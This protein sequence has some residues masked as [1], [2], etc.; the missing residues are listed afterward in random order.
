[1][2][3]E[4][5]QWSLIIVMYTTVVGMLLYVAKPLCIDSS[6]VEKI[7]RVGLSKTETIYKCSAMVTV[8]YSNYFDEKKAEIE[9]RIESVT[10]FLNRMQPIKSRIYLIIDETSPLLFKVSS[11]TSLNKIQIGSQLLEAR[12]HLERA[13]IKAWL[14]EKSKTKAQQNLFLEVA[15]DFLYYAF[16]GSFEIEDPLLKVQTKLGNSRWPQVLKSKDGYCESPWKLSE[17]YWICSRFQTENDLTEAVLNNLSIRPLM[18]SVWIKAFS[19]LTFRDQLTFM[20]GFVDYLDTQEL[21]SE[22]AIQMILT[23]SHP[24]K[25]G[26]MNIKKMTDRMNSSKFMQNRKDYREFF[27]R[28]TLNLQQAGV[29][30]SFAEAY[31]DYLFEYPDSLTTDSKLFQSLAKISEQNPNLQFAV[32]DQ[33]QIWILPSRSA[34]PLKTFDKIKNQQHVFFACPSLKEIKMEQFY[35]QSEKL[36]LIK[37]CDEQKDINFATLVTD[38]VQSFSIKN[39]KLAFIQFHLPSFEMKAKELAHVKNFFDLVK[40]RDVSQSELQALGW[41]QIQWLDESQAYRPNAVVDAIQLFRT[42]TN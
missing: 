37:G 9:K 31:F 1:M 10:A 28:M 3:S 29:N 7:D 22:K 15:T 38:G 26:M 19:E 30:D 17:H 8:P 32:K 18:T 25:Q 40:N 24:L 14:M 6:S 39:K 5:W 33:D 42:E 41:S 4:R 12:G 21:T 36:L 13:L 35:N 16:S 23:D 11:Q 2:K 27:S 34:L 20:N